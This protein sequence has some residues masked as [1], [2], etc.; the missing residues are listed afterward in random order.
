MFKHV[1]ART[2]IKDLLSERQLVH[3][4]LDKIP[5]IFFGNIAL[6]CLCGD[7]DVNKSQFTSPVGLVPQPTSSLSMFIS[8][9][10][11]LMSLCMRVT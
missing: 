5:Y 9:P 10:L 1:R 11:W 2:F 3:V 4:A 7:L 8:Q 6:P